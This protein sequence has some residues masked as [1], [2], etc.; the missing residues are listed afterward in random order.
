MRWLMKSLVSLILIVILFII[1]IYAFIQTQWGAQKTSEWLTQYT[2]YDIHFSGIEHDL[3]QPEQVIVYDLLV[4]PKQDKAIVSAKSAQIRF[5]WQFFTTPSHLQKITLENGNIDLADKAPSI[6][7]SAD[8]LQFKNMALRSEKTDFSFDAKKI[9]GG[10][11]PWIPTSTDLIGAGHFQFSIADGMINNNEFS[12]FIISGQYQP[13]NIQIEKL[14]TRLLNGSLSLSGQYQDNQWKFDNVYM[15]G[16]RWQSS[17]NFN[18]LIQSLSEYPRISIRSL[19]IVDLTAEG[20][21]WAISGFDGQFSQFSWNNDLSFTTGEFNTNDVVFQDEHITD[22]IAK[23]NLQNNQLNLDNL[24]LR[25]EKGLIKLSGHWNKNNKT[26][27]IQDATLSGLLYTLPENWL[28]F[29]AKPIDNKSNIQNITIEQLSINQSILID[30]TPEF[31]FQFT[32]LTGKLQNLMVAKEGEWGLWQGSA[33]LNAD[34]GTLNRIE[35]RRPDLKIVT[36]QDNAIVEQYSAFIGDGIVRGS[37]GLIQSNQQRQF[38]LIANGL[39]VPLSIPYTLGLKTTYSDDIGQFTL[40]LKG[41]LRSSPVSSTLNGTLTGSKN[42]QQ[43]LNS[44]I[45]NG[46]IIN[47]L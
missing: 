22:L 33:V 11:T 8:I 19:N 44:L 47:H 15:N 25:Y 12:N 14:G 43:I 46:E 30:I 39:N 2:D 38:S 17:Q 1:I 27:T 4:N 20:K 10:I 41:D 24:S 28:T 13:N 18:E 21:Q 9:T 35:L 23:L 31:P 40:K 34:S 45:Q 3:M 6:P 16:L 32:N 42:E 7:L 5:N 37:A 29:L 36:Q 26:L